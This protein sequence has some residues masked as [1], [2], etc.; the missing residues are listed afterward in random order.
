MIMI[1]YF[2]LQKTSQLEHCISCIFKKQTNKNGLKIQISKLCKS[3]SNTEIE[4]M[5]QQ[6]IIL[7]AELKVKQA[8]ITL[9]IEQMDNITVTVVHEGIKYIF[10]KRQSPTNSINKTHILIIVFVLIALILL[11]CIIIVLIVK[12]RKA[13][14]NDRMIEVYLLQLLKHNE[15]QYKNRML[16]IVVCFKFQINYLQ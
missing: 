9:N 2:S 8:N 11:S 14:K 7:K 6:E 13:K 15:Q 16:V 3:Q 12:K 10:Y 5:F 4:I 1:L